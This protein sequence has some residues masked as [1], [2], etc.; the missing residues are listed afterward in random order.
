MPESRDESDVG[1]SIVSVNGWSPGVNCG[2][3]VDDSG[4]A[5]DSGNITPEALERNR[6]SIL[7]GDGERDASSLSSLSGKA[8][9]I[10]KSASFDVSDNPEMNAALSSALNPLDIMIAQRSADAKAFKRNAH[11]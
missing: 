9:P 4:S 2:A 5:P 11:M 3:W 8:T 7:G 1:Q 10:F 6:V